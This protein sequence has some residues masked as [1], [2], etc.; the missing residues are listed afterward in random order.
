MSKK[1]LTRKASDNVYLHKD[2]HGALS[3]G[4]EYLHRNFGADAVRQYLRRFAEAFYRPLTEDLKTRGLVALK[5][6]FEKIYKIE[7]AEVRISLSDDQ[8]VI[9]V[10]A[11]PAV[12]HMRQRGYPIAELFYETTRTVN[13]AI[14][15]GSEF[16]ADL[17]EYDEQTGRSVQRFY[18]KAAS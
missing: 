8:L 10:P 17:V 13:E 1:V 4:I 16:A 18:R 5:E 14:C 12:T 7:G 11:C 9:D 15:A 2:F 6:H 3:A